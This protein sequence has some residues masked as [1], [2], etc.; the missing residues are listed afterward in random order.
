[1]SGPGEK[2]TE[3]RYRERGM[4]DQQRRH[5]QL[6]CKRND[7]AEGVPKWADRAKSESKST[8]QGG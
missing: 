8:N 2:A 4:E 7:A 6:E 3:M 1:M 5:D